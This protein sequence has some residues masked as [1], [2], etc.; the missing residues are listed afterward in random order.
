MP[1]EK[2]R[3][4]F[5]LITYRIEIEQIDITRDQKYR[6]VMSNYKKMADDELIARCLGSDAEAWEAL[7]RRYQR[8]ISSITSKF[9]LNTDDAADVFQSVWLILFQ[10]LPQL[11]EQTKLSSWLIT[12]TVRECWKLRERIGKTELLDDE[13]WERFA[14]QLSENGELPETEALKLERQ[15]LLRRAIEQLG[16]RCRDL[17][18]YLFYREEPLSY[19]EIGRRMRMPIAS[20]G[21]TRSRCLEKL[22]L[23]LEKIGLS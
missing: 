15:H 9:R 7:V 6:I 5:R 17:I 23:N 14:E 1:V 11:K 18:N 19:T 20:I 13:E 8:L 2:N 12:I 21:P 16:A 4:F 10:Q 22:K 3:T